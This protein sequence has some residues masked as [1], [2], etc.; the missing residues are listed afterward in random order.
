MVLQS[1]LRS[2]ATTTQCGRRYVHTINTNNAYK[3]L[4]KV[5]AKLRTD[6]KSI[7][8]SILAER[9]LRYSERGKAHVNEIQSM[10]RFN[11]L[12]RYTLDIETSVSAR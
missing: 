9:L 11:K 12:Q 4:R 5:R 7:T 1:K 2:Y 6:N 3:Q 8:G 10:I